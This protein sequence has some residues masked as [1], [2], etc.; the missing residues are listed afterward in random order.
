[1]D[2]NPLDQHFAPQFVASLPELAAQELQNTAIRMLLLSKLVKAVVEHLKRDAQHAKVLEGQRGHLGLRSRLAFLVVCFVA[3]FAG[4]GIRRPLL[5]SA[6]AASPM[7][8]V[9]SNAPAMRLGHQRKASMKERAT[10]ALD[11]FFTVEPWGKAAILFG[12]V[13][14]MTV[15]GGAAYSWTCRERFMDAAW[16]AW[17]FIADPAKHLDEETL[18]RRLVAT[19]LSLGGMLFF[20]LL[21]GIVSDDISGRV[22]E[23]KKGKARVLETN[24]TLVIGWTRK[25][26]HLVKELAVANEFRQQKR[27]IVVMGHEEKETMDDALL[28]VAPLHEREGVKI[29]TRKG[30][31]MA[32]EDLRRCAA[33]TAHSIVVLSPSD[34]SHDE[35]D[36]R[37]LQV[38]TVLANIGELKADVVAEFASPD[39]IGI[40]RSMDKTLLDK[41]S[42]RATAWNRHAAA[43]NK[44]PLARQGHG[45]LPAVV[46]RRRM[47]P[48]AA[49]DT[50]L[51]LLVERALQPGTAAVSS[52][53]LHFE[54]SEFRFG[55]W[56]ELSGAM[57][58]DAC[59]R[60]EQAVPC[61]IW[62]KDDRGS[63]FHTWINPPPETVIQE[64]D[65]LLLISADHSSSKL[66]PSHA[67]PETSLPQGRAS[68]TKPVRNILICEWR[69]DVLDVIRLLDS[70]LGRGSQVTIL[71]TEWPDSQKA[72]VRRASQ[73]VRN[74]DIST[75]EGDPT[76]RSVLEGL[77]LEEF[78]CVILLTR[79]ETAERLASGNGGGADNAST[80]ALYIRHIQT[81]RGRRDA[82]IVAELASGPKDALAAVQRNW[83]DD[84]ILPEQLQALVLAQ[85]AEDIEVGGVL[86]EIVSE[87]G[88]KILLRDIDTV[89]APGEVLSFWE[90]QARV[91]QDRELMIAH[92]CEANGG[93][94][95][96]NPS[97]KSE[98]LR[99]GPK[100]Q[101]IVLTAGAAETLRQSPE[102]SVVVETTASA[103]DY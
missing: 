21:I 11:S 20:A 35:A 43:R 27:S 91:L 74:V 79:E 80:S 38:C 10:Y 77:P 72:R 90:L 76:S 95:E 75:E 51:R 70:N 40:L 58:R 66:G 3:I 29:V 19:P 84:S 30:S 25:T 8:H 23:L 94:W 85:V 9:V 13:G 102:A 82:T 31:P 16:T 88:S 2:A 53:L 69:D 1:M 49:G 62:Q 78:D 57:F 52:E 32:L 42:E 48:V 56:P 50:V 93:Q 39:N 103:V 65:K 17:A 15:L 12:I 54:G 6:I 73:A 34:V 63:G 89:A 96:L 5:P 64:G 33:D 61:G 47:V 18:G 68:R 100:D 55:A 99:W 98:R 37:V 60:F 101:I 87:E 14:C 71:A 97:N 28:E 26:S 86:G 24:H 7:V 59:F 92:K 22:D 45:K 36:A 44:S 46:S 4:F 81:S 41:P 83:L 67:P